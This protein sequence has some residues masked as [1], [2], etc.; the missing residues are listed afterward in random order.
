MSRRLLR[1]CLAMDAR[2]GRW[3]FVGPCIQLAPVPRE[4]SPAERARVRRSLMS[5]V[6]MVGAI[7][8]HP[9]GER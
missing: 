3:T 7:G 9:G 6:A 1:S 2:C 8:V 4:V 5:L